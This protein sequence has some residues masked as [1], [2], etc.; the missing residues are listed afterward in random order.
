MLFIF[1]G[2]PDGY[3]FITY[4]FSL[5][6]YGWL[7]CIVY[8]CNIPYKANIGKGSFFNHAGMGVLVNPHVSIG[9]KHEN[10]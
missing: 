10:R 7:F 2:L 1:I 4:L 8:N 6:L 9:E 3:I 5:S